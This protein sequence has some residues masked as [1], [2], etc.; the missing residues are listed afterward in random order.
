M[1]K[2][3]KKNLRQFALLSQLP[4]EVI[5]DQPRITLI[6]DQEIIVENHKG[7]ICYEDTFVKI[8]TNIS[9]LAIEGDKLVI[10]RMDSETIIINGRIKYVKY[11]FDPEQGRSD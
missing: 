7:L 9:P 5:T 1:P 3:S 4:Q 6:G 10:E 2:I 11:F 8:N